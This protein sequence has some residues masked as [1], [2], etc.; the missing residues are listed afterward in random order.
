MTHADDRVVDVFCASIGRPGALKAMIESVRRCSQ[1]ARVLVAAGDAATIEACE[2]NADMCQCVYSSRAN[3]RP[4]CT[5]PL[6]LVFRELVRGNAI[7]CTDDVRFAPDAISVAMRTL[8]ERFPDGDG[9][10]G[11]AQSNLPQGYD[12]AFPLMG[13]AFL[14]RFHPG[15]LFYPGYYHQFNDAELGETVKAWGRWVFEPRA[16]LEHDHPAATGLPPDE[17]FV[18]AR[19][20]KGHDDQLWAERR[21]AG[22]LWAG[23]KFPE[24]SGA[25]A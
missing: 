14:E 7:F 15:D 6:N 20:K 19:L 16:T 18:R 10:V 11:L 23:E 13:R 22:V 12:L 17:T 2:A 25:M 5:A 9:V 8:H 24:L 3:A 4:G 21:A 1:P